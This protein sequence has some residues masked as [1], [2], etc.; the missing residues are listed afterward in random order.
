[1]KDDILVRLLDDDN[2]VKI[3]RLFF[4]NPGTLYNEKT[5]KGRTGVSAP[6]FRKWIKRLVESELVIERKRKG[7]KKYE[8]NSAH[9]LHRCLDQIITYTH[10]FDEKHLKESLRDVG[11]I[12]LIV[13]SGLLAEKS[14][15]NLD[16]LVVGEKILQKKL[17]T[18]IEELEQSL[19]RELH[20]AQ[21]SEEE[22]RYRMGMRDRLLRDVFDFGHEV[23]LDKLKLGSS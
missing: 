19:G 13:K 12:K 17:K 4:A 23:V 3:M 2:P 5:V 16:L 1:M 6:T 18:Q 8:L 20:Y 22:F 11:K 10:D 14:R 15:S 21:F 7:E 9:P